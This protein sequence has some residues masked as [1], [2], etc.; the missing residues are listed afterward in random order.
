MGKLVAPRRGAWIEIS[1]PSIGGEVN[2]VAPRRG[3]WI[4]IT[5]AQSLDAWHFV[6][7]RRGAWIE[8]VSV[9]STTSY[10]ECRTPQGC[11]DRN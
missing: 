7:P 4:E 5:Y 1:M 2:A 11:V 9:P 3:A 10:L 6:A 8:I